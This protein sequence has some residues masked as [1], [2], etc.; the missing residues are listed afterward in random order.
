MSNSS[1]YSSW[2]LTSAGGIKY[3]FLGCTGGFDLNSG[4]VTWKAMLRSED[5]LAFALEL[6][7][8]AQL[9]GNL[10]YLSPGTLPGWPNM[11]AKRI[12]FKSLDGEGGLPCDALQTDS[13]APLGTYHGFVEVD[14]NF[15]SGTGK[16]P[17]PTDPR[18]FLEITSK[19]GGEFIYAPPGNTTLEGEYNDLGDEDESPI[20]PR[21]DP[22]TG[23]FLGTIYKEPKEPNRNPILPTLIRVPTTDWNIRWKSIPAE[24]Y[25]NVLVHRLRYLNGRVN[26]TSCGF[27]YGAPPETLLFTGFDH[28]EKFTWNSGYLDNPPIDLDLKITEKYV[29]WKGVLCGHN[30]VWEPGIGWKRAWIGVNG[31]EPLYRHADFNFLF[32]I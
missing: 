15:S 10:A 16:N 32:K 27:L 6:F 7:P 30:H 24:Y 26:L 21:L 23:E 11:I 3:R 22:E 18:T 9:I 5:F 13:V 31:D 25:R 29:Y 14:V 12:N 28:D 19:N 2:R 1:E 20:A 4:E 8:S 17:D